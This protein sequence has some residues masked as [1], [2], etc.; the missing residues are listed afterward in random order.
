GALE[1]GEDRRRGGGSERGAEAPARLLPVRQLAQRGGRRRAA[2][3]RHG[4]AGVG[5]DVV[6]DHGKDQRKVQPAASAARP[7]RVKR[8][9]CSSVVAAAPESIA[10]C[11]PPTPPAP[12]ATAPPADDPPP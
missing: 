5:Q 10:G 12:A 1:L 9:R 8:A 6:E 11:A 3:G 7:R 2:S 4:L